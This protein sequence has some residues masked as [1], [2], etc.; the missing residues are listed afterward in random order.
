MQK[1]QIREQNAK[2]TRTSIRE[3]TNQMEAMPE[4]RQQFEPKSQFRCPKVNF[5]K[6]FQFCSSQNT[7]P[8]IFRTPMFD[9]QANA[10]ISS[11]RSKGHRSLAIRK[12]FVDFLSNACNSQ[13]FGKNRKVESVRL[14][15]NILLH[16]T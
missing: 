4:K 10:M 5:L 7:R 2:E 16:A 13:F 14:G 1:F 8:A 6:I 9:A 15:E 12:K 11:K 3:F